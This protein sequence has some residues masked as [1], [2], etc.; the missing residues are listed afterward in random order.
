MWA[1]ERGGHLSLVLAGINAIIVLQCNANAT[2]EEIDMKTAAINARIAPEL[3]EDVESI[4]SRLGMTT[5]QAIT[6]Y[7]EQ[8]KMKRGLPFSV[9]LLDEEAQR[10][11]AA[12]GW[13]DGYFEGLAARKGENLVRPEQGEYETRL[14]FD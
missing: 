12:K 9:T 3:K 1:L 2:H 6:M 13:P 8:I 5:T 4:L 10:S 11:P 14:E 7:F